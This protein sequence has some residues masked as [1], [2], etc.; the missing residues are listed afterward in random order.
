MYIYLQVLKLL[1]VT[2]EQRS[3]KENYI[4]ENTWQNGENKKYSEHFI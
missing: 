4:L 3:L 2:K 1:E